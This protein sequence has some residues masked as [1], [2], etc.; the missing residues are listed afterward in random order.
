MVSRLIFFALALYVLP[1]T[2]D[3]AVLYLDPPSSTYGRGDTFTMQVRVNNENECINA[4]H[5]EIRYP[6]TLLRAVDFSRGSSILSLWVEEPIIDTEKGTVRFAGGVPGGYCGRIQGDPVVSNVLGRIV[7]T[8]IGAGNEEARVEIS[9]AS[10]VYLNDGEGTEARV[11]VQDALIT[12]VPNPMLSE[13][14]WLNEVGADVIP[15]D[16]F[17][18]HI[19]S[20]EGVFNGKYFAVFSTVDKQSGLD[21]Y[22]IFERGAWKEID[23][24]YQFRDQSFREPIQVKAIDKGGNERMGTFDPATVPERKISFLDYVL[25]IGIVLLLVAA[26]L[27]RV[28]AKRKAPASAPEVPPHA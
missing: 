19:E 3:A 7:F 9:K 16:G 2:V 24:P 17:V 18:V 20:T 4:A 23:S 8:V 26:G 6:T 28:Y 14:E 11:I 13:N 10:L 27:A 21:H 15:P 25:I 22:E 5:V 12:T 1:L